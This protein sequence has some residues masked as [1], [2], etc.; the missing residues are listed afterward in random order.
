MTKLPPENIL[1]LQAYQCWRAVTINVRPATCERYFNTLCAFTHFVQSKPIDAI[2]RRDIYRFSAYLIE[3]GN[4]PVTARQ[5]IG[6]LKTIFNAALNEELIALNPVDGFKSTSPRTAKPR[7]AFTTEDL[8]QLFQSPVYTAAYLP[9]G[10]GRLACYWLPLLALYTG[11]RVE[12]LARLQVSDVCVAQGLGHYLNISDLSAPTAQLK[13]INSRRRIP[14]HPVLIACG[15]LDLVQQQGAGYLLPDLKPNPR[16]KL[17]G[18]FSYWFSGY[19]RKKVGISDPRKVFH[20]FRHTFKDT[21]RNVGIEE[22]VH[23]ALTGHQSPLASRSYGNEQF[24]LEPLFKAIGQFDIAGL[25]L[26][27]LLTQPLLPNIR[28]QDIKVIAAFYGLA[29]GFAVSASLLR[30]SPCLLVMY[31][32]R[33]AG[34]DLDSGGLVFGELPPNKAVLVSAWIE[35]HRAELLINWRIGAQRGEFFAIEALR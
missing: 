23:D 20:S 18:Y 2:R 4:S 32:E 35:I 15:F 1:Y 3:N 24:P 5:K 25:D 8:D 29:V 7:I 28:A 10:G 9:V 16:G 19:L 30:R 12:E 34:F 13:N 33:I 21:C 17:G 11:A 31:E 27:H 26:S 14:I 22:A 6:I